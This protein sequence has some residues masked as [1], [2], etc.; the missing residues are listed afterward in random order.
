MT[1]LVLGFAEGE[2][3]ARRFAA[4]L[5][6]PHATVEVH[7][8]PDREALVRVPAS[9]RTVFLYRS[10]DNPDAKLV[11]LLLAA[12]AARD[13]GARRIV[14]VAP[15]LA[16][17]RQDKAFRRGEAISQRVM[18][19]LIATHFQGLLTVNPHLHRVATLE[20]AVP[21][22]PAVAIS[23]APLLR[24]LIDADRRSV[25]VGPDG[26]AAQWTASIAGPLG[27]E[28][29]TSSKQRHGD[30]DISITIDD[31]GRVRG[32]PAILVDDVISSGATLARAAALL[33]GAGASSVEAIVTHCLAGPEDLAKLG[34]AGIDRISST[35]S[36][37]GPAAGV[38]LS[39]LLADA[40]RSTAAFHFAGD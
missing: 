23:A 16:Y 29:L 27:L 14:L 15:Y 25:I 28:L 21:W 3:A 11:E 32:R 7:R 40:V 9:A 13:E 5:G 1:A 2:A 36:V 22:I 37:D 24:G 34:V 18:G 30:R 33:R 8:F 39:G 19:R 26:E 17:M 10:L 12:S 35:D 4:A 20:E 6:V 31:L 38:H